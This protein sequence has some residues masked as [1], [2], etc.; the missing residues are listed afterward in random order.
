MKLSFLIFG[1]L[2]SSPGSVA[3]AA[4]TED[5]APRNNL[6]GLSGFNYTDY[7]KG[8]TLDIIVYLKDDSSSRRRL[9]LDDMSAAFSVAEKEAV[10]AVN[11]AGAYGVAQGMGL[12]PL[13]TYGFVAYG[14]AATA[15]P[16]QIRDVQADDRVEGVWLDETI[17]L[18]P[19]EVQRTRV[20]KESKQP[21]DAPAP[22]PSTPPAPPPATPPPPSP[23]SSQK[24]PY[25]IERV[26]EVGGSVN[27]DDPEE[28]CVNHVWVLDTGIDLDH[29]D[30]NVVRD[31]SYNPYQGKVGGGAGNDG[32]G[33]GTHVAGTIGAIDNYVGVRG[34]AAGV[35]MVAV[36]VLRNDGSG[37]YAGVIAGIDYV[38]TNAERGD[39]ANLSLGGGA[40]SSLDNAIKNAANQGIKMVLAAGNS[41]DDARNYSPARVQHA[42]AFTIAAVDEDDKFASFSNY[43]PRV[44]FAAPGV[45]VESLILI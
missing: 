20:L 7:D 17:H 31:L 12:T 2:T 3:S 39:V 18:P 11:K 37:S 40:S 36:K 14:F 8:D 26:D 5:A 23:P 27:C 21:K 33:H 44:K 16:D 28:T 29:E 15:T 45:K 6:R 22:S 38:A 41:G 9:S 19:E 34:V 32:H 13:H 35:P 1:A 10:A 4:P 43:G 42:N 30:L 25:G 24:V